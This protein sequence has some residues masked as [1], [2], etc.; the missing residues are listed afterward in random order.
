MP[1]VCGALRHTHVGEIVALADFQRDFRWTFGIDGNLGEAG[2][3][4]HILWRNKL[5][6]GHQPCFV[7]AVST[8]GCGG[9]RHCNSLRTWLLSNSGSIQV[10][11]QIVSRGAHG[12]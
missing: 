12:I 10:S 2:G 5:I 1:M 3:N 9:R 7:G 4:L 8:R 11:C 6:V